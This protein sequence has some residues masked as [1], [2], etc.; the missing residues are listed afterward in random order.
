MTSQ[1][2][3]KWV[4][5]RLG[6]GRY[7]P[8]DIAPFIKDECYEAGILAIDALETIDRINNW[9]GTDEA[10]VIAE[11]VHRYGIDAVKSACEKQISQKPN[12]KGKGGWLQ[13]CPV[14]GNSDFNLAQGISFLKIDNADYCP[15]CGQH[16]DW[17]EE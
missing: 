2:A 15:R 3:I 5:A 14:C 1:E 9:I 13:V 6:Y 8:S 12:I 11:L 16:I 10:I 7:T 17:S 4:Q